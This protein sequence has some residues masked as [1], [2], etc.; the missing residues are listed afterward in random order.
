MALIEVLLIITGI[1]LFIVTDS[2]IIQ[3]ATEDILKEYGVTYKRISG[4]LFTGIEVSSLRYNN[5]KLVESAT[6]YWN[7]F[8]LAYDRVHITKL[9]LEG[10]ELEGIINTLGAIPP[11]KKDDK[12]RLLLDLT[13]DKIAL[14]VNPFVYHGVEFKNF[15]FGV[16]D[17]YVD[18]DIKVKSEVINFSVDSDLVDLSLRGNIDKNNLKLDSLRLL[19]IDPKVITSFVHSIKKEQGKI[20]DKKMSK[21]SNSNQTLAIGDISID[22]FFA[23][24]KKTTYGPITID[25]TKLIAKNLSIDPSNGFSYNAKK[26]SISTDTSFAFTKQVGYIKD[27]MFHGIGDI[28]TKKYLYDRYSLPLNQKVLSKIPAKLKVNHQGVW[29]EMEHSIKNLLFLKNS[30]FNVDLKRVKH[31]VDYRYSDFYLKIISKGTGAITYAD[32][33]KVNSIVD[34]DFSGVGKTKV[35]YSGEVNLSDI[36]N[37]PREISENLLENLSA[38]YI[39]TPDEL[40]VTVDSNQIEGSFITDKYNSA[41]LKI[42][43]KKSIALINILEGLPSGSIGN[44]HSDSYIDFFD[45]TQSKIGIDIDSNLIN[46]KTSMM[47]QKPFTIDF[48]ATIPHH[49]KISDID[50]K[51]KVKNISKIDG[52]II[53]ESKDITRITISSGEL[54]LLCS[55]N[56][57]KKKF[58]RGV[59][60][61]GEEEIKFNGSLK[62]QIDIKSSIKNMNKFGKTINKYYDIPLAEMSGKADINVEF[63]EDGSLYIFIKSKNIGYMDFKG[64]IETTINIDKNREMDIE[65]KSKKMAYDDI[66][67][68]KLSG[69]LSILD[70]NIEVKRYNF[71]FYNDYISHF[72]SDK[73][74]HLRYKDGVIYAKKVWLKNNTLIEGEY[75]IENLKGEFSIVSDSFSFKNSD[76]DLI[77]D[78]D[79]KLK[80]DKKRIFIDGIITPFGKRITYEAIGTGISEDSDI[81]IVQE[82]LEEE[83]NPLNR[84]K[85]RITIEHNKPLKYTTDDVDIEFTNSLILI[86]DYNKEIKLLGATTINSGY[87]QKEDKRFNINESHI[88]FA[89]DPKKPLLEIKATYIKEQYNIQIFISGTTDDPIINFN[90]DPYLTQKEILS[91]ILFDS[92]GSGNRSGT[93]LY[94]LLGGTFTKE[95]MKSLGISVDHLLLGQGVD[96]RLS[97][98]IGEKISDNITVI[99]QHN[100]G[101]DGVKVRVDHSDSF[102]TDIILQPP[103]SSSIEFLY[104]SDSKK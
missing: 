42:D 71:K 92:I 79:L 104:K 91:L 84:I 89:G 9:E 97:V 60:A 7:P 54:A 102:E 80:L 29:V 27:S 38:K 67:F 55:Y 59:I 66:V 70:E 86:K 30:D 39:G 63:Y 23:T 96:E 37:I 15:Y 87:Y 68:H 74:S 83:K 3:I 76:F 21:N 77:T 81:I 40:N 11:S 43:T 72:Y 58:G 6:I 12:L 95:V 19:E 98:E 1:L 101:K 78:Y 73:L 35:V 53:L 52:E 32:N 44:I 18:R 99:Y 33:V 82:M 69:K 17:L 45:T 10:V 8:A 48:F 62:S 61:I 103:N 46:L 65:F 51:I 24:M 41:R 20:K 56:S 25:K 2:H 22:N 90:S 47:I 94:A 64:D 5:R 88:Y 14:K 13:I 26:A 36:K 34:I 31:R 75:N 93:E 85:M 4:N 50:N 16:V 49:S 28:F 57:K 100:N